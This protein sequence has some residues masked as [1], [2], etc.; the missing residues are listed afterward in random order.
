MNS[1]VTDAMGE[2]IRQQAKAQLARDWEKA[3]AE[4]VARRARFAW[5]RAFF[6]RS[7]VPKMNFQASVLRVVRA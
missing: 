4:I 7:S 1:N 2:L 6:R 5:I 3:E